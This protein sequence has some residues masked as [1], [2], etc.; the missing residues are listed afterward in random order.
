MKYNR[1]RKSKVALGYFPTCTQ[2]AASR[3]LRRWIASCPPLLKDLRRYHY[4]A[5]KHYFT[6]RQYTL[7]VAHFGAPEVEVATPF[8][9]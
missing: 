1:I 2:A 6:Y 3:R 5:T 4:S 9:D 8:G 7:L